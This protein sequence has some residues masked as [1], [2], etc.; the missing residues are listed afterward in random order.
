MKKILLFAFLACVFVSCSS[1]GSREIQIDEVAFVPNVEMDKSKIEKV[2]SIFEVLPGKYELSWKLINDYPG[3]QGYNISLKLKLRLKRTVK[4]K[5]E[6]LEKIKNTSFDTMEGISFRLL[7]ADGKV[8]DAVTGFWPGYILKK[9]EEKPFDRD[10]LM[11]FV[12]FL[13]SNPGTEKEFV[14]N[15]AGSVITSNGWDCVKV[16]KTANGIVCEVESD[17]LFEGAVGVIN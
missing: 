12:D 16:C 13:Q 11:E 14:F 5:D 17:G 1:D 10:Q 2:S 6:Y 3:S 9:G 8:N 4:V 15:S 7:D